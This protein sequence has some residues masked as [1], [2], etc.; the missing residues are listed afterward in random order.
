MP[1]CNA[2]LRFFWLIN[3]ILAKIT[4]LYAFHYKRAA[5]DEEKR[6]VAKGASCDLGCSTVAGTS[7]R[8]NSWENSWGAFAIDTEFNRMRINESSN[9]K[10][11]TNINSNY[12]VMP[13]ELLED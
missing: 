10:V 4:D 6:A 7:V 11:E 13:A 1:I 9:W 2:Q 3:C 5:D 12:Q 8:D